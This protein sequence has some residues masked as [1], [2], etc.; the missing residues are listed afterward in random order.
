MANIKRCDIC[1]KPYEPYGTERDPENPNGFSF[2]N[3]R[4]CSYGKPNYYLCGINDT[5]PICRDKVNKFIEALKMG[6][7]E[8]QPPTDDNQNEDG[9]TEGG[10][11]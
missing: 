10:E 6:D 5:C 3:I 2:L 11:Q 8:E 4:P 9:S 7:T 1:K